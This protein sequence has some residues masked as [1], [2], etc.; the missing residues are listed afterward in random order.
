MWRQGD[1]V[2]CFLNFVFRHFVS[3]HLFLDFCILILFSSFLV[4]N[5]MGPKEEPET[6]EYLNSGI[7]DQKLKF[8][9]V[10]SQILETRTLAQNQK[11]KEPHHAVQKGLQRGSEGAVTAAMFWSRRHGLHFPVLSKRCVPRCTFS[12]L[13]YGAA[14]QTRPSGGGSFCASVHVRFGNGDAFKQ[15]GTAN[16]WAHFVNVLVATYWLVH[17]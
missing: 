11:N 16:T 2:V 9:N 1:F 4:V 17:G 10:P 7:S 5:V 8:T 12:R 3:R 14:R 15:M 13:G 6:T